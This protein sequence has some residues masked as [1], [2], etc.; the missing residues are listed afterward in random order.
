MLDSEKLMKLF[1]Y[2]L[3]RTGSREVA[4]DLSS[5]IS[6]EMLTMLKR[7]YKPDNFNAWMWTVARAKY[8]AWSKAKKKLHENVVM[9]DASY[10]PDAV[11]DDN[12]ERDFIN[13]EE[14]QLLRRE[15]AIMSR[16]YR[17]ITVA[18]YIEN[19]RISDIAKTVNLPEGTVKRKLFE[20][21]KYL[22]EG[23]KMVRTYGTRSYAPD[24]VYFH[25][26][27]SGSPNA[28]VCP[29]CNQFS[30]IRNI[31]ESVPNN[32]FSK[33]AKNILL[34]TYTNPCSAEELSVALGVAA[35]YLEEEL[36]K[37]VEGLFLIKTK[38]NKYE[39]DFIIL[40]KETQKEIIE[41]AI[42]TAEKIC[43]E[44]FLIAGLDM[45]LATLIETMSVN[46]RNAYQCEFAKKYRDKLLRE[47]DAEHNL[48][49]RDVY[50]KSD[51]YQVIE[52]VFKEGLVKWKSDYPGNKTTA[53]IISAEEAAWFYLFKALR[54]L[55]FQAEMAKQL[56]KD[57][58]KKYKDGWSI[59]GFEE[60]SGNKL[61][62]Y[63]F[64][65]EWETNEE[66]NQHRFKFYFK[67]FS[68]TR[69]FFRDFNLITDILKNNKKYSDLSD[70]EKD[71]IKDLQKKEL[72]LL[73]GE[74]IRTTFPI[75]FMSGLHDLGK[76]T[77][78]PNYPE[79]AKKYDEGITAIIKESFEL[80]QK[81]IFALYEFNFSL[82]KRT[83]PERLHG[84]V[85]EQVKHCARDMLYYLHNAI[86][87]IATE[88]NYL[89][90]TDKPVGIGGYVTN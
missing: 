9:G 79:K 55:I 47:R 39:T 16:E 54:D 6:L 17:E 23:I 49:G 58:L 2:C 1:Y 41:K 70:N 46:A 37:L 88:N 10:Y 81:E 30:F 75:L 35:P 57:S 36:D 63:P 45:G 3:K 65:M 28:C 84:Q 64:G 29:V 33:I 20:S 62:E 76:L 12:I 5:E 78:H 50:S 32:I 82:I 56:S 74:I 40:D 7:G 86:L 4:E 68:R 80:C 60:Y 42:E 14:I 73:E 71:I 51:E 21:R 52:E 34:E 25:F 83:L 31:D 48:T 85:Q 72:V 59:T 77:D 11:S 13:K 53:G 24:N 19:R 8:A 22:K 67:D 61:H 66:N 27:K 44:L 87:K 69:P 18:Y 26:V 15:L 43:P 38:D 89:I 90:P